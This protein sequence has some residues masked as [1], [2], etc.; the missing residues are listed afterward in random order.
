MPVASSGDKP[1]SLI[2][3]CGRFASSQRLAWALLT[4]ATDA[5]KGCSQR[6]S[7]DHISAPGL[8]S[9]VAREVSVRKYGFDIITISFKAVP[10]GM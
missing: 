6:E 10:A 7:H 3:F 2:T 8:R 1:V 9:D 5:R 4:L